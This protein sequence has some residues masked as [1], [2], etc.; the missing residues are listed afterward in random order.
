MK[1]GV[2]VSILLILFIAG[3]AS[4]IPPAYTIVDLGVS[5]GTSS[6]AYSL[7]N[8]GQVVGLVSYSDGNQRPFLYENG[9]MT[10][11]GPLH[12]GD[13]GIG[14]AYDINNNGQIAGHSYTYSGPGSHAFVTVN[15][16]M[17]D[18]GTLGGNTSLAKAVNDKGAVVGSASTQTEIYRAFIDGGQGMVDIH[19]W[20]GSYGRSSANDINIHGVVVGESTHNGSTSVQDCHAFVYENGIMKD[21]GTLGYTNSSASAINDAGQIVGT[22]YSLSGLRAPFLYEDG[23]MTQIPVGGYGATDI[24]NS[25]QILLGG[26]NPM[27]YDNGT[28]YSLLS[29]LEGNP[30]W[31]QFFSMVSINDLGWI[32]G[33]GYN[34]DGDIHAFLMIPIPEPVTIA[35]L[36]FGA[37]ALMRKRK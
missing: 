29:L 1:K 4:A 20:G 21:L 14:V 18:L 27:L 30:G 12:S 10:N 37:L 16:A 34:P 32:A 6:Y 5:D 13:P 11:L 33:S 15:G 28:A 2:A 24:N 35:L 7:N 22:I 8:N 25:G 23:V 26:S 31:T 17:Q 3:I 9:S 36:G 19:S